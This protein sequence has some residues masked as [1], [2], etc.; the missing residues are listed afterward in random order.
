MC[1]SKKPMLIIFLLIAVM[2][3]GTVFAVDITNTI[4][5]ANSLVNN[6]PAFLEAEFNDEVEFAYMILDGTNVSAQSHGSYIL[7]N[8][9]L[10]NLSL[11]YHTVEVA[12]T[13]SFG[14]QIKTSWK[15]EM[16][17][18]EK[19]VT[20]ATIF[21]NEAP[22]E[23]ASDES[24]ASIV[25]KS[26]KDTSIFIAAA[27]EPSANAGLHS[28]KFA[29]ITASD[30]S[31]I[32]YPATLK[33][34]YSDSDIATANVDEPTLSIYLFNEISNSWEK[35][36]S[37]VN[38]TNNFVSASLNH[39]ST[40]G[41]YGLPQSTSSGAG[42]SSGGG[43]SGGGSGGGGAAGFVCNM[44]WKCSE[45][46]DCINGLQTRECN[47]VKVPQ[48]VQQTQC[49]TSADA[50]T[51]TKVCES[52]KPIATQDNI[53]EF[54]TISASNR[55]NKALESNNTIPIN[56]DSPLKKLLKNPNTIKAGAL[57]F[58]VILVLAGF[59]GYK[60]LRKK[61]ENAKDE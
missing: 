54:N 58:L 15:F 5:L 49:P 18:S 52:T 23:V 2:A 11:G 57:S 26:S 53:T 47:F 13:D 25:A 48:H 6:A 19:F 7:S 22:K 50:Q 29:K 55:E 27:D 33:F 56:P 1:C 9:S 21:T 16:I 61:N 42:G 12:A 24:S 43:G 4:P 39:L 34:F 20:S 51:T 37:T 17:S 35:I 31:A 14:T 41:V 38:A 3:S 59:F 40:Y 28:L 10:E 44:D 30:S 46:S 36:S 8:Q 45:W 32:V 60:I